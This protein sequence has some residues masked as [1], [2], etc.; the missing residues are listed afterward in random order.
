MNGEDS[1]PIEESLPHPL[2]QSRAPSLGMSF[3]YSLYLSIYICLTMNTAHGV[4]FQRINVHNTT[5]IHSFL[6]I[7][8][9]N[10]QISRQWH[11]NM[12]WSGVIVEWMGKTPEKTTMGSST[13]DPSRLE[14]LPSPLSEK[15]FLP[16]SFSQSEH[17]VTESKHS[18]QLSWA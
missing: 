11:L 14:P 13:H 17:P 10:K 12:K 7:V 8:L 2:P 1:L 16:A 6:L 9:L 15:L 4:T 18:A 3:I 5:R